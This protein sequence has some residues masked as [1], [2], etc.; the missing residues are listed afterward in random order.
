M[1]LK[2]CV[3]L[4]AF[5]GVTGMISCT[6]SYIPGTYNSYC[7]ATNPQPGKLQTAGIKL[8]PKQSIELRAGTHF[9]P[10]PATYVF[11]SA[12]VYYNDKYND[13]HLYFNIQ[14]NAAGKYTA[15]LNCDSGGGLSPNQKSFTSIPISFV[16][17]IN[18]SKG[19]GLLIK[20]HQLTFTFGKPKN[21][22]DYYLRDIN[23]TPPGPAPL[24]SSD[25][26]NTYVGFDNVVQEFAQVAPASSGSFILWSEA[27]APARGQGP[28]GTGLDIRVLVN[29]VRR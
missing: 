17:S 12:T 11:Q 21:P 3:L 27:Q 29:L 24:T 20:R 14:K 15:T 10:Q 28:N 19:G 26:T 18:Y 8:L 9:T 1:R 7:P 6:Q 16:S 13:F 23:V 22:S 25:P 4:L 5:L 2:F